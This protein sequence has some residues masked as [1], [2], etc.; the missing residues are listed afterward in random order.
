MIWTLKK[1]WTS[2]IKINFGLGKKI[3]IKLDLK[4]KNIVDLENE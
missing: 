3:F 1:N 4:I 2:K